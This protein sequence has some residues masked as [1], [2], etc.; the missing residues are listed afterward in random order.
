MVSQ[1]SEKVF[2][3]SVNQVMAYAA[4]AN[5]A[6]VIVLAAINVY[7][8]RHAKRQADASGDQVAA[9]NRQAE[10]AQATLSI[11]QEQTER[12]GRIDLAT[13]RLQI[14]TALELV[15]DWR[16][17][18]GCDAYP[19]LPDEIEILPADFG[20]AIQHAERVGHTV[21]GYMRAATLYV[22]KAATNI[23]V[24]RAASPS[25][26]PNWKGAQEQAVYNLKIA[27]QKLQTA[28]EHAA[29]ADA[30][31]DTSPKAKEPPVK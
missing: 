20:V 13:V 4:I 17:R 1:M 30:V 5:I 21:A 24:M 6:L 31:K 7:Y 11:L 8:A 19:Q 16:K 15:D 25:D 9:S 23:R 26:A 14:E 2:G 29:A 10:I 3:L 12:Q 22:A 18:I 27:R 28:R